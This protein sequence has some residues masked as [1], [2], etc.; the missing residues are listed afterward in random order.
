[1][2]LAGKVNVVGD[3]YMSRNLPYTIETLA[4]EFNRSE[5]QIKL[6]LE[7]F[8]ELEMIEIIDGKIYRVKNFAKHQNIKVKE[9]A[10]SEDKEGIVKNIEVDGK[11][12]FVNE[13]CDN[14]EKKSEDNDKESENN[15]VENEETNIRNEDKRESKVNSSDINKHDNISKEINDNIYQN[16]IP[17][18]LE[19]KKNKKAATT[20]KKEEV[21]NMTDK[22]DNEDDEMFRF[23]EG[24]LTLGEGEQIM[25]SWTF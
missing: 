9:K 25:A 21:V 11:E 22:E 3:L 23:S 20:K 12:V 16:N 5:E 13:A 18:S 19:A 8:I 15:I 4:I 14:A 17:I 2:L 24:E 10:K 1:M 7:V 6:A